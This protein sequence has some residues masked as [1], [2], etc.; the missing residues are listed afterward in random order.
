MTYVHR[1][2]MLAVTAAILSCPALGL[3]QDVKSPVIANAAVEV[4]GAVLDPGEYSFARASADNDRVLIR[5]YDQRDDARV[6]TTMLG[7]PADAQAA[8]TT[9]ALIPFATGTDTAPTPI[10]YWTDPNGQRTYELVYPKDRATT[11]ARMTGVRVLSADAPDAGAL[12]SA[13]VTAIV[14]QSGPEEPTSTSETPTAR[15]G[16]TPPPPP[17]VAPPVGGETNPTGTR[18]PTGTPTS[19]TATEPSTAGG[20][21]SPP[22]TSGTSSSDENR[23]SAA[24]SN[25]TTGEPAPTPAV[26]D[27]GAPTGARATT[28]RGSSADSVA[29]PQSGVPNT[30]TQAGFPNSSTPIRRD[31]PRPPASDA[32]T[33]Y[34]RDQN[35]PATPSGSVPTQTTREGRPV[36]PAPAPASSATPGV[37]PG[38]ASPQPSTAETTPAPQTPPA[39]VDPSDPATRRNSPATA[40]LRAEQPAQQ[41]A[42][43]NDMPTRTPTAPSSQPAGALPE[44]AGVDGWLLLAGGMCLVMGIAIRLRAASRVSSR[45]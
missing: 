43:D 32:T 37:Q 40:G 11:L 9:G 35:L 27:P 22:V 5:V 20:S 7:V 29:P 15:R 24:S 18:P 33:G 25:P 30:T 36:A 44:T 34:Q 1:I 6:I 4:P 28:P 2:I 23:P 8:T 10:R 31:E 21:S 12:A 38:G 26:T 17:N 14:D 42:P 3:A 13:P 16:T 39:P 41:R 19:R 45:G